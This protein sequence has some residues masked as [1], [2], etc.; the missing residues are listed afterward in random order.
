MCRFKVVASVL[1][2]VDVARPPRVWGVEVSWRVKIWFCLAV[3]AR[4]STTMGVWLGIDSAMVEL[5][6]STQ[7]CSG[8]RQLWRGSV[9]HDGACFGRFM[10]ASF[11]GCVGVASCWVFAR[12]SRINWALYGLTWFLLIWCTFF[13]YDIAV[14]LP[15]ISKK[16]T[17]MFKCYIIA[18]M[19]R[20]LRKKSN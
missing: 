5:W 19:Q 16:N 20:L 7:A 3:V 14:L 4:R 18:G 8:L 15:L 17:I 13:L 11:L 2:E 10:L 1:R 6:V 12:F 9:L